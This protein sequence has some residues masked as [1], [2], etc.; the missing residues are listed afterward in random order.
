MEGARRV[1]LPGS[2]GSA[3]SERNLVLCSL[4]TRSV[5]FELPGLQGLGRS[6][7]SRRGVK[8][9]NSFASG[10]RSEGKGVARS[11]H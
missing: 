2:L 11:P 10:I 1:A 7:G 3:E 8:M 6:R 5:C 4:Q 9:G